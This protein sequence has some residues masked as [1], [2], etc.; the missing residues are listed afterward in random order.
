ME[1]IRLVMFGHLHCW[2]VVGQPEIN[3]MESEEES[4][5]DMP[6][7]ELLRREPSVGMRA[8]TLPSRVLH[9]APPVKQ[10]NLLYLFLG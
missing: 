7:K 6:I 1:E 10:D 5:A 4:S 3:D 8:K 2:V 9:E